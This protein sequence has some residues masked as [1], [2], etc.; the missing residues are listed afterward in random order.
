MNLLRY[1]NGTGH[2]IMSVLTTI[3]G[4]ILALAG[5]D[6]AT[7]GIGVTLVLTVNTAWF[8]SGSAKQVA[9]EVIAQMSQKAGPESGTLTQVLTAVPKIVTVSK[10]QDA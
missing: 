3:T 9:S 5:T 10:E 6:A 2:L 8:V 7:K 4:L 1:T